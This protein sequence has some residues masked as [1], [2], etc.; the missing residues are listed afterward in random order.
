[1]SIGTV[2]EYTQ[3][4]TTIPININ[5]KTPIQVSTIFFMKAFSISFH[6]YPAKYAMTQDINVPIVSKNSIGTP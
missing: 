6:L 3:E 1:M 2:P 5:I 4:P